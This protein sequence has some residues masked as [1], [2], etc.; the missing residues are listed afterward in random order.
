MNWRG[1]FFLPGLSYAGPGFRCLGNDVYLVIKMR[2]T[3]LDY[4]PL[5]KQYV[6]WSTFYGYYRNNSV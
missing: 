6:M 5:H 3:T 1:G 2:K 4:S